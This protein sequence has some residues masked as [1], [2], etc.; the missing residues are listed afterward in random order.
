VIATPHPEALTQVGEVYEHAVDAT[1]TMIIWARY[2]RTVTQDAH[3]L[4]VRRAMLRKLV[5]AVTITPLTPQKIEK[6][7][8]EAA[9]QR[10]A[11]FRSENQVKH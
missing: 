8:A 4:K 6:L 9:A 11:E 3:W 1:H 2:D 5:D 10:K 7:K